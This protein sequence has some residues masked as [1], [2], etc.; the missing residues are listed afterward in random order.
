M[1]A[2]WI[3]SALLPPLLWAGSNMMDEHLSRR[4]FT[5]SPLTYILMAFALELVPA[6]LIFAFHDPVMAVPVGDAVL[7]MI[8]GAVGMLAAIP[9]I[10]AMQK[11]GAAQVVPM[12]QLIPVLVFFA[13]W[14]FLGETIAPGEIIACI[15]II[16]AVIG[17]AWDFKGGRFG[18]HL[19]GLMSLTCLGFAACTILIRDISSDHGWLA[20]Y[21]W[22]SLSGGGVGALGVLSRPELR[23]HAGTA[24]RQGRALLAGLFCVQAALDMG[25]LAAYVWALALAPAAA[26]VSALA[27]IQPFYVFIFSLILGI[28]CP[29]MYERMKFDRVMAW[30][31]SC[32][33]AMFAG[34]IM[35]NQA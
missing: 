6:A 25:A 32:M 11:D 13:G 24:F 17:I 9:Y 34:V 31:L 15:V 27:G 35:L 21:G 3:G 12:F 14:A 1:A 26:L 5:G 10:H 8:A 22:L 16:I 33:A 29:Q 28:V 18:W 2:G 7:L 23:R 30:R 20:I 19:I 4:H